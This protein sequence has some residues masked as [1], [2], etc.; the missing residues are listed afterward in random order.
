MKASRAMRDIVTK[1]RFWHVSK[2]ECTPDYLFFPS[3]CTHLAA[4]LNLCVRTNVL[5][6]ELFQSFLFSITNWPSDGCLLPLLY[7]SNVVLANSLLKQQSY[8]LSKRYEQIRNSS[9]IYALHRETGTNIGIKV[10][11]LLWSPEQRGPQ[12]GAPDISSVF[13][14]KHGSKQFFPSL[15]ND[16]FS[17]ED[18]RKKAEE[19]GS[20]THC[21][22]A[23]QN[24][25][26]RTRRPTQSWGSQE[27]SWEL[28]AG[29]QH[30]QRG[31]GAVSEAGV[32]TS[33]GHCRKHS[34]VPGKAQGHQDTERQPQQGVH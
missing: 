9:V 24:G 12:Q 31:G 2:K 33:T 16:L 4:V 22:S 14:C 30:R 19:E 13:C 25:R 17:A 26:Y 32:V 34:L 5:L 15:S 18:A 1:G 23:A 3:F 28:Q 29:R 8:P 7:H 6:F 11:Y 10:T 27:M 21:V 20:Q